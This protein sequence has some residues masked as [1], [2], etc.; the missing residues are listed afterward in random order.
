MPKNEAQVFRGMLEDHTFSLFFHTFSH[1]SASAIPF[2]HHK[3]KF[4]CQNEKSFIKKIPVK[5]KMRNFEILPSKWLCG[6][7]FIK[8]LVKAMIFA[9]KYL[10]VNLK[11]TNSVAK[12]FRIYNRLPEH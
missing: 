7:K 10:R 2:Y 3:Y 8:R 6:S 11:S 9:S 5:N 12:L 1:I 4:L